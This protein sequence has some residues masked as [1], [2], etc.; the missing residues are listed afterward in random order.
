VNLD[1]LASSSRSRAMRRSE[2][3]GEMKDTSVISPA[4]VISRATSETRRMFSTRSASVKP[5]SG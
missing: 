3:N 4:S 5:R 2:R 1:E